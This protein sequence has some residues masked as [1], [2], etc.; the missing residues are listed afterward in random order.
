[1]IIPEQLAAHLERFAVGRLGRAIVPFGSQAS[2]QVVQSVSHFN[3]LVAEN[4]ATRGQ[5]LSIQE[6]GRFVVSKVPI[7]GG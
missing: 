7:Q 5:C 6:L 3:V 4:R 1:M 2:R